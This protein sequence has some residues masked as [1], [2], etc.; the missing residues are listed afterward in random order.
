MASKNG[1]SKI[2]FPLVVK[3]PK[4]FVYKLVVPAQVLIGPGGGILGLSGSSISI[5]GLYTYIL[6]WKS[7]SP[8][9]RTSIDCPFKKIV[10]Y[11]CSYCG[12]EKI[13]SG[14]FLD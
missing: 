6:I 11:I 7:H 4:Q 8:R 12:G 14:L 5:C 10:P 9:E 1:L 2:R 13:A 3:P